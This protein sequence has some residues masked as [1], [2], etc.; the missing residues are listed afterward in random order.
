MKPYPLS[1]LNHFTVPVAMRLLLGGMDGLG[2]AHPKGTIVRPARPCAAVVDTRQVGGWRATELPVGHDWSHDES[3]QRLRLSGGRAA[4]TERAWTRSPQPRRGA[5]R[6]GGPPAS[7]ARRH[8]VVGADG[9]GG[10]LGVDRAVLGYGLAG[11]SGVG[12]L[13]A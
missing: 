9:G 1:E 13:P 11:R 5:V 7:R 3:G 8:R 12:T 4:R 10:G 6:P 2:Q